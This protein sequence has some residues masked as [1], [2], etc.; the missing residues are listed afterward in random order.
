METLK[1]FYFEVECTGPGGD[2]YIGYW[3]SFG[4]DTLT[5]LNNL[6]ETNEYKKRNSTHPPRIT[7]I[8]AEDIL[9]TFS[10]HKVF[11]IIYDCYN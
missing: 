1:P 5:A 6:M 4:Y 10:Q 9:K 7:Q 3:L 8:P 11:E 2:N